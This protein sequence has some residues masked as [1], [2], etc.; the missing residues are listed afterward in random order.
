VFIL[1]SFAIS[2]LFLSFT[3]LLS[4]LKLSM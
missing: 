4:Y 3:F 1:I 2:L